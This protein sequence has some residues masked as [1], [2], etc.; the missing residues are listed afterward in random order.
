LLWLL[1]ANQT[2]VMSIFYGLSK[3]PVRLFILTQILILLTFVFRDFPIFAFFAFAPMF[4]LI[5]HPSAL[6]DFSL[7]FFVAMAT[8]FILYSF[9]EKPNIFQSNVLSWIIYFALLAIVFTAYIFIQR[10]TSDG[11]N[12]FGLILLILGMEYILLK[13]MTDNNPVF[14]ADLFKYKMTWTRWNIFTGYTGATLWILLTNLLFY[15]GLFKSEK[16]NLVICVLAVLI[17]LVP[18]VYSLN[19]SNAALTKADVLNFYSGRA[20]YHSAYSE[21]G[22]LISRTGAWVSLLILI[23]TVIKTMT[24]KKRRDEF[25]GN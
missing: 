3:H 21:H 18:L 2:K 12:K 6:K 17:I 25:K 5:D 4:A 14:M 19:S 24:K 20:E 16:I 22:E 7:P 9:K 11:L 1:P 13:F 10:W 15:H 23:F 8:A